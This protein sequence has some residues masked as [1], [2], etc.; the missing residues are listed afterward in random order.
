MMM[1]LAGRII[2][3]LMLLCI[4]GAFASVNIPVDINRADAATL[5]EALKGV[6]PAKAAAI[7]QYRA[8]NGAFRT[9]D[10]LARVKG[11]GKKTIEKNRGRVY[12]GR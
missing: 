12:A 2:L 8:K 10:D 5:D 9:V 6:G 7:V 4:S 3:L 11:I 1:K